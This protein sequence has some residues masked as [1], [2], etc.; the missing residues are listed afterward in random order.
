MVVAR[1]ARLQKEKQEFMQKQEQ[2][3]GKGVREKH[4][5]KGTS[6][7][8]GAK[9]HKGKDEVHHEEL[10]GETRFPSSEVRGDPEV[11]RGETR[12]PSSER[13]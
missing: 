5:S 8:K 4:W 12:H 13:R 1:T 10:V 7:D 11:K 3:Q 2:R 6:P 9:G